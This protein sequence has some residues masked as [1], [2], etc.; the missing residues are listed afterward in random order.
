MFEIIYV[1]DF[2]ERRVIL[3]IGEIDGALVVV[4]FRGG[5]LRLNQHRIPPI[6]RFGIFMHNIILRP[7]SRRGFRTGDV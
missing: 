3:Y 5:V 4:R 7:V 1:I 6:G 2:A